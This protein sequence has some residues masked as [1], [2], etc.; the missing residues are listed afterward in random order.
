MTL[1]QAQQQGIA[2]WDT[3]VGQLPST[4]IFADRYPCT[5]GHLLFVPRQDNN[6]NWIVQAMEDAVAHGNWM[7]ASGVCDGFNIGF[8]SGV[9]AGQTVMYPHIHLIPRRT[10]DVADPVGGV[11]NTIPGKGNYKT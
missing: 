1:A 6:A 7:V 5:P 4:V 3:V 9:S 11:R 2:P 10:G 8:N